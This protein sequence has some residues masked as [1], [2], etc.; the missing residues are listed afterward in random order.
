MADDI[1][2]LVSKLGPVSKQILEISA[3]ETVS[4][5]NST[6]EIEHFLRSALEDKQSAISLC[7]EQQKL[8]RTKI[9]QELL[10]SIDTFPKSASRTPTFS[11]QIITALREAWTV[12]SVEF[13][14][15]SIN[16]ATFLY[17]CLGE[18]GLKATLSNA[19]AE[20][21]RV[22][23]NVLSQN[24]KK[25]LDR[26]KEKI[27]STEA[28]T[29]DIAQ[30]ETNLTKF[31]KDLTE[32]ARQGKIDPVIG[33]DKEIH[34]VVN[35]L[36]RRRQN[37][38]ILLGKPGVGK[39]AIVEGLAQKLCANELSQHLSD[40]RLLALDLTQMAA[41]ASVKGE[42]E[43]RLKGIINEVENAPDKVILFIDEAHTLIGA[44]GEAGKSDAANILKPALA[45][46]ELRVI[47]ATT[48][49]EYK[50][51]IEKDAALDRRFQPVKV[52][53]P[54]NQMTKSLLTGLAHKLEEHH[55]VRIDQQAIDTAVELST[56]Y[57]V[58]RQQPDKAISV[59]D[60]A[61]SKVSARQGSKP[62]EIQDL[63]HQ[64]SVCEIEKKRLESDN[65]ML[66]ADDHVIDE[67]NSKVAL[68]HSKIAELDEKFKAEC[69]LGDKIEAIEK[70]IL[71]S[72]LSSDQTDELL[73]LRADMSEL[74]TT[75]PMIEN[76]VSKRTV[77]SVIA[78]WT[79][80][81]IAK[82]LNRPEEKIN[83]LKQDLLASI[84]GQ[85]HA[86]QI[87]SDRMRM[88]AA[89]LNDPNR[90]LGVFLLVGPSG[91][92]K[93]ETAK[94]LA[95]LLFLG[96]KEMITINM[97]EFQ[98]AHSVA[99]LRGAPPGYVGYGEGGVLTEAVKR[100][101]HN[102]LLLD[103]FEKAHNDVR[104]VFYQVFD[105]GRLDD[106]DGDRVDFRNTLIFVTSNAASAVISRYSKQGQFGSIAMEQELS[107]EL[108]R[109]FSP[110]LVGRMNIVPYQALGNDILKKIAV[111]KFSQIADR[112]EA[113]FG[114]DVTLDDKLLDALTSEA[115]TNEHSGA[116]GLIHLIETYVVPKIT[117]VVLEVISAKQTVS[118]ISVSYKNHVIEVEIFE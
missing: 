62:V 115:S 68:I 65:R 90:P 111:E 22:D 107:D 80:I 82:L 53:E 44:G 23:R 45:R 78:D 29:E 101:P 50:K 41:G 88:A 63:E 93:T 77:A 104:E 37:N 10:Q 42:Y 103:E 21:Y 100:T 89:G 98:E 87:I 39:T 83:N 66:L 16:T 57:I 46:G 49:S 67:I 25:V 1:K 94:A 33:R 27:G 43:K 30:N 18:L 6:I 13:D 54:S 114:I 72:G 31:T 7:V 32:Q 99:S 75:M 112:L 105:E 91:V 113:N 60:T 35:I 5:G 55:N 116:R 76:S 92:G 52:E 96:G 20:L 95:D 9:I 28:I 34:E 26:S 117:D 36:L 97:S 110:A 70:D 81:P 4:H 74:Q 84:F 85:D 51:Y 47:A 69:A 109:I 2:S 12:G 15:S 61:C 17:A 3:Q 71:S 48:F 24:L 64:L 40:V 11:G 59:L 56:R 19:S 118:R 79:S 8:D 38:P 86:C 58:N 108:N 102:V 73:R 106:S 14:L